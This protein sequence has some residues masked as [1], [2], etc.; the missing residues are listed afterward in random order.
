[1]PPKR[2]RVLRRC[3]R[4]ARI[5]AR[6]SPCAFC[7]ARGLLPTR[8]ER[9]K[10][11][12][13]GDST[14]EYCIAEVTEAE[15]VAEPQP[16]PEKMPSEERPSIATPVFSHGDRSQTDKSAAGKES[17]VEEHIEE[18]VLT[19]PFPETT[20]DSEFDRIQA[21]RERYRGEA[22]RLQA[23]VRDLAIRQEQLVKQGRAKEEVLQSRD[24][25]ITHMQRNMDSLRCEVLAARSDAQ[26]ARRQASSARRRH[27]AD[28]ESLM[29][30]SAKLRTIIHELQAQLKVSNASI[31]AIQ[32]AAEDLSLTASNAII[33]SNVVD[34]LLLSSPAPPTLTLDEYG[35]TEDES[36][37]RDE[38]P[39]EFSHED[40]CDRAGGSSASSTKRTSINAVDGSGSPEKRVKREE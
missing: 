14:L 9:E 18:G 24:K 32:D 37:R 38:R 13:E 21:S 39:S 36:T 30:Y 26:E 35:T 1:M 10:E 29:K 15:V 22:I 31:K 5:V 16:G 6:D 34:D 28:T 7:A 40:A 4:C 23:R 3:S 19:S 17:E 8:T 12:E 11:E 2:K 20:E 33:P 27:I 25:Q